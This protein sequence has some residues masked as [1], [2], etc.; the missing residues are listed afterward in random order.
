ME[1]TT[2]EDFLMKWKIWW[3]H[4]FFHGRYKEP[5]AFKRIGMAYSLDW[6]ETS[7][8][9]NFRVGVRWG[10]VCFLMDS[11]FGF[12]SSCWRKKPGWFVLLKS[13]NCYCSK[14]FLCRH[15][16]VLR[17]EVDLLTGGGWNRTRPKPLWLRLEVDPSPA[18]DRDFFTQLWV[19][20]RFVAFWAIRKN[21][22]F[23]NP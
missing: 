17:K 13:A 6:T 9:E 12:T 19:R 21:S 2:T 15:R 5:E 18:M 14:A 4:W 23:L 7:L 10:K 16:E 3:I 20:I 22:R 11:K 8:F 1:R